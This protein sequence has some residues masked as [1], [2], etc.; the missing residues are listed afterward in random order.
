[1]PAQRRAR[2]RRLNVFDALVVLAVAIAFFVRHGLARGLRPYEITLLAAAWTVPLISRG[3]AQ[4]S[5]SRS[6]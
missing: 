5:R 3:V 1:M 6:G 4:S 2:S